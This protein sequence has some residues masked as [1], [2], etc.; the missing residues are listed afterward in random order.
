MFVK[1]ADKRSFYAKDD[2]YKWKTNQI[3]TE[4]SDYFFIMNTKPF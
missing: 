1:S 2:K 4:K 3:T